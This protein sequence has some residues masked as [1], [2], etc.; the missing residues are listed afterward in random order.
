MTV[1]LNHFCLASWLTRPSAVHFIRRPMGFH[2]LKNFANYNFSLCQRE[3][4]CVIEFCPPPSSSPPRHPKAS[5]PGLIYFLNCE[6]LMPRDR[7]GCQ[8]IARF[9]SLSVA[10]E[11]QTYFRSSLISLR[12]LTLFG[13][14][15]ATTG[16]TSELRRL[17]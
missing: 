9:I 10:R 6:I 8:S 5:L 3:W 14:R 15:E 16:N 13:G 1:C 2:R 7:L 11:A 17:L 4:N 12:K